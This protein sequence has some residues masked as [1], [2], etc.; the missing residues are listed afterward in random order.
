MAARL[1]S[2]RFPG[3]YDAISYGRGTWLFHMLR[4]MLQEGAI[5]ERHGRVA[6]RGG[7]DEPFTRA[8]RKIRERYQGKSVTTTELFA[9][10]A[11]DLPPALRYE[12]KSSFQWFVDGW[13]NG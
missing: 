8:L 10:F 4:T 6:L 5:E 9:V 2:S 11:E 1:L 3:G 12:G 7:A 13:V